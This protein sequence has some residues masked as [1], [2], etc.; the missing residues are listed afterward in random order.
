M[1]QSPYLKPGRLADVIAA[2]QVMA[3][4]K[5]PERL[6]ADWAQTF[7]GHID[8]EGARKWED[9]FREHPEFF[10]VYKLDKDD[11]PKAALRWRYA[12]KNYDAETGQEYTPTEMAELSDPV[13]WN[14]TSRPLAGD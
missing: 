5:R 4:A 10:K 11:R 14:L 7:D 1:A 3:A 8:E 13:R 2:L 9:V 12:F 6:I